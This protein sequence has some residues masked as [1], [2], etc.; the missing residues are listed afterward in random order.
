MFSNLQIWRSLPGFA[1][2]NNSLESFNKIIKAQLINYDEQPIFA[3]IAIVINHIVPYFSINQ[4]EFLF[5][6]VPHK[7]IKKIAHMRTDAHRIK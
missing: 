1:N 7:F 4:K 6:R 2:T 5:Y 3:I